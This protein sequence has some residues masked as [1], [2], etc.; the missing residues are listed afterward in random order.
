MSCSPSGNNQEVAGDD[1]VKTV[2]A[3]GP[4]LHP[5]VKGDAAEV[6]DVWIADLVAFVL[7]GVGC[8]GD[9]SADRGVGEPPSHP[10]EMA[11]R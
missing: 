2:V 6:D 4:V 11:R 5:A 8:R 7:R 10:M 3:S 9:Q 1:A